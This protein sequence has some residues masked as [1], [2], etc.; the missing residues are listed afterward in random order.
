MNT[1]DSKEPEEGLLEL[2]DTISELIA[3]EAV[4][5]KDPY[6]LYVNKIKSSIFA[7]PAAVAG[8]I[9]AGYRLL[10]ENIAHPQE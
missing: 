10:L 7:N 6:D 2:T 3:E 8:R 1:T 5:C 4:T 9:S